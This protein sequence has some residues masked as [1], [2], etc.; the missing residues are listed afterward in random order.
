MCFPKYF[1][2]K[3]YS[4]KLSENSNYF[5]LNIL[6]E[7]PNIIMYTELFKMNFL[8]F[9]CNF[10]GISGFWFGISF[11]NLCTII[12]KIILFIYN[13]SLNVVIQRF[14]VKT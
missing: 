14:F 5:M 3:Y 12:I 7:N 9:I 8:E 6:P 2:I 4:K 11:V 13:I 1:S 10:G